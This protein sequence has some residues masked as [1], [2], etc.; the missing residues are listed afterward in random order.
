MTPRSDV[1]SDLVLG[2]LNLKRKQYR[3]LAASKKRREGIAFDSETYKGNIYLL[4]ASDGKYLDDISAESVLAFLFKYQDS[5]NF[6]FSGDYDW[7]VILKLLPPHILKKYV[8][9]GKLAFLVYGYKIEVVSKKFLRISKGHKTAHFYDIAQF[10]DNVSLVQAH[11]NV[12][13]HDLVL[14]LDKEQKEYD[15]NKTPE[16]GSN[17]AKARLAL[18]KWD[19]LHFGLGYLGMKYSRALVTKRDYMR[20]KKILQKYVTDDCKRTKELAD[21]WV[22][23]FFSEYGFY[24]KWWY[25]AGY[26]AEKVLIKN[27]VSMPLFAEIPYGAQKLAS[28]SYVAGRIETLRAGY[29][30]RAYQYD[31]NSAYPMALADLP[32][33]AD[34]RWVTGSKIHPRARLGFFRIIATIGNVRVAPFPF[35]KKGAIYFPTGTFETVITLAELKAVEDDPLIKYTVLESWQFIPHPNCGFPFHKFILEQYQKRQRLGNNPVAKPIKVILNSIYGKTGQRVEG[36]IGNLFNPVVFAYITGYT[37]AQVYTT[38]KRYGLEKDVIAFATD[39]IT[40]SMPISNCSSELGGLKL[41][42]DGELFQAGNGLYHFAGKKWKTR[43]FGMEEG[44]EINEY[45]AYTDKQGRVVIKT[46]VKTTHHAKGSIRRNRIQDI[47]II[48]EKERRWYLNSD[49]KRIWLGK[50]LKS[51]N[52]KRSRDSVPINLDFIKESEL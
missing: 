30:Q 8:E 48:E 12:F 35:R 4:A 50:K 3:R 24:P 51:V 28:E 25:S 45:D 36:I 38:V 32:D 5:W 19:N 31:I 44:R 10:F 1:K 21:Y 23:A 33:L 41:A 6:F 26:L 40:T 2:K 15:K 37:R 22:D 46:R 43:G 42:N 7:D 49:R 39:S 14:H 34:G 11:R 52:E 9:A 13:A 29:I 47:G 16:N 20:N 17:L 18:H 27:G